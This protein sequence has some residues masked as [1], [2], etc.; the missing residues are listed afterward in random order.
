MTA[1]T[2][3]LVKRILL[4][5]LAFSAGAHARIS[6]ASDRAGGDGDVGMPS[7]VRLD[8]DVDPSFLGS[9][10]RFEDKVDAL[11]ARVLSVCLCPHLH[12]DLTGPA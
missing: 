11:S 10:T 9:L 12:E 5:L 3:P 6:S 7:G 8:W 2:G 4:V 1:N